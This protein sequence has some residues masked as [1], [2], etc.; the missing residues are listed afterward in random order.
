MS[1]TFD[2]YGEALERHLNGEEDLGPDQEPGME[3]LNYIRRAEDMYVST[4]KGRAKHFTGGKGFKK[5]KDS[6]Y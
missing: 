1:D 2:H 4:A 6:A 5:E 3:D